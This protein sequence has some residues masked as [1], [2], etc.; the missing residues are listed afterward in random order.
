M[1]AQHQFGGFTQRARSRRGAAAGRGAARL[2]QLRDKRHLMTARHQFGS[3]LHRAHAPIAAWLPGVTR[4]ACG[5]CNAGAVRV[6]ADRRR[7]S[8][9]PGGP[10]GLPGGGGT[11]MRHASIRVADPTGARRR[12]IRSTA[13]SRRRRGA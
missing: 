7:A 1:T 11:R 8:A 13:A 10:C 4:R 3:S 12:A 6:R 2:R 9:F 5:N